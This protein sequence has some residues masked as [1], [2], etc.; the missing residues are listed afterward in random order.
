MDKGRERRRYHRYAGESLRIE[1][2]TSSHQSLVC[3]TVLKC[4]DFNRYGMALESDTPMPIG[5]HHSFM[6]AHSEV[7]SVRVEAAVC[8][9]LKKDQRYI[10]GVNF[11]THDNDQDKT[12]FILTAIET[13]LSIG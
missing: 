3:L 11:F 6:I 5:E 4:I 13:V 10:F 8:Y 9:R 2:Y 7:V 1:R 12:E